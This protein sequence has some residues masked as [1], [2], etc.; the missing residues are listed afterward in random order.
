MANTYLKTSP[1]EGLTFDA[2]PF[3]TMKCCRQTLMNERVGRPSGEE[4]RVTW[5]GLGSV[6]TSPAVYSIH[7]M[8]IAMATYMSSHINHLRSLINN[9]WVPEEQP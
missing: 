5:L 3:T 9:P 1:V 8:K 7:D 6:F 4:D 2:Y